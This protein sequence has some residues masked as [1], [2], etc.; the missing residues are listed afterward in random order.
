[1]IQIMKSPYSNHNIDTVWPDHNLST[2]SFIASIVMVNDRHWALYFN[3]KKIAYYID[4]ILEPFCEKA[5]HSEC[6]FIHKIIQQHAI[7]N[8]LPT[9]TLKCYPNI[10][11]FQKNS[12]DC[13]P[14][15]CGYLIQLI[16]GK[17]IKKINIEEIRQWVWNN[18]FE[19]SAITSKGGG[20][21]KKSTY[22]KDVAVGKV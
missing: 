17:S 12:D 4:P 19:E 20:P 15:S 21:I 7:E 6:N 3:N 14:M 2:A 8:N 5:T 11:D 22:N 9:Q 13:G 10:R 16:Q 1:M 18:A